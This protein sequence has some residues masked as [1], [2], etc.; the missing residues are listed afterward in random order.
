MHDDKKDCLWADE[1][2]ETSRFRIVELSETRSEIGI[3]ADLYGI[4]LNDIHVLEQLMKMLVYK[5]SFWPHTHKRYIAFKDFLRHDI[6]HKSAIV[7]DELYKFAENKIEETA[8][9]LSEHNIPGYR[10]KLRDY[11][12]IL[13][14]L[15]KRRSKA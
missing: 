11:R 15:D 9:L 1:D 5:D 14:I 8:K 6:M 2:Y 13:K 7:S 4:D 12:E 10:H 3:N